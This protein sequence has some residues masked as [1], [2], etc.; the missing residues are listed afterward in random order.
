MNR[1]CI[2]ILSQSLSVISW[3]SQISDYSHDLSKD[4]VL[5]LFEQPFHGPNVINSTARDEENK[6]GVPLNGGGRIGM[7]TSIPFRR[8]PP[9]PPFTYCHPQQPS[10][11][12]VWERE[13][14][15]YSVYLFSQSTKRRH[16]M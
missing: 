13:T 7:H 16:V 11:A 1:N 15:D 14:A 10:S 5:A 6:R 2:V 12:S 8:W 3:N 9:S 4:G